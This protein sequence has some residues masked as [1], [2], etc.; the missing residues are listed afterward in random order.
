MA[1][2]SVN[3]KALQGELLTTH[4]TAGSEEGT[5]SDSLASVS[6][7]SVSTQEVLS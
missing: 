1:N 3:E 4:R 6:V 5:L 2:D 7:N